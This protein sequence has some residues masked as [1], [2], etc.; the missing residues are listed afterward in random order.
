LAKATYDEIA[1][2]YEAAIRPFE[3]WF[4]SE[5]RSAALS[6]LPEQG[7]LLEI[8]AGTGLNFR[9]YPPSVRGVAS[10]PSREMLRIAGTKERSGAIHLVQSCAE[11]IPFV[12]QTFDAALATLVLCS[13]KSPAKVFQELRRVVRPGGKIILLEHVRPAGLLGPVFDF[14]NLI[15]VPL[16]DDHFNRRTAREAEASGLKVLKSEKRLLGIV[17]LI[18]CQV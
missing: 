15:T 12:D 5:L 10:E 1:P 17:N 3:R 4:L 8:G 9:L 14:L 11:D 13:V 16:F 18:E 7:S 2:H 6:R